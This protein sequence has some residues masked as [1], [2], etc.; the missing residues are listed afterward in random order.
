MDESTL[1]GRV[2]LV[3]GATRGAGRGIA[4]AL[5]EAGATVICTGR[6]SSVRRIPSDYQRPETIE[7][8]AELRLAQPHVVRL[9]ARPANAEGAGAVSVRDLVRASLRMMAEADAV[10]DTVEAAAAPS[11]ALDELMLSADTIEG[12]TAFAEKRAPV[13]RGR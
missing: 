4:A 1:K 8:T 3:A 13:W 7:E 2:A 11:T 10:A 6:S 5:G 12:I 9:E